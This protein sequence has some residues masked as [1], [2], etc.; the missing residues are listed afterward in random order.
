MTA[1]KAKLDYYDSTF[2]DWKDEDGGCD[3]DNKDDVDQYIAQKFTDEQTNEFCKG[4]DKEFDITTFWCDA[5]IRRMFP[6]LS[7]AAIGILSIP[8]SSAS[9]ERVFST[10]GRV[11]EKRR[12][13]LSSKSVDSIVYLHSK[14]HSEKH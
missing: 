13:Q 12:T 2:D 9:S 1:K 14:H 5:N 11:L 6:Q 7:L 3:E 4:P 8:A 10:T